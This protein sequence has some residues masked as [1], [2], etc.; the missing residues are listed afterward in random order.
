M[1]LRHHTRL[2][3]NLKSVTGLGCS[4]RGGGGKAVAV[5]L[6]E[7]AQKLGQEVGEKS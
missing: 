7:D 5:E 4:K 3:C 2:S 6:K 1:L